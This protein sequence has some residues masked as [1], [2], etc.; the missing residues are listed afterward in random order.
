[1]REA[2]SRLRFRKV[3]SRAQQAGRRKGERAFRDSD[4]LRVLAG[5]AAWGLGLWLVAPSGMIEWRMLLACGV[6][7]IIIGFGGQM[8]LT[9]IQS[10]DKPARP[11]WLLMLS[12]MLLAMIDVRL[13]EWLLSRLL[14]LDVIG[15]PPLVTP[16]A[17]APLLV[18]MLYGGQTALVI[19]L[20]TGV[21]LALAADFSLGVFLLSLCAT[22]V[23]A[24][25]VPRL[26]YRAQLARALGRIALWQTPVVL[27]M[28]IVSPV[29]SDLR[30]V[31]L[32]LS[33]LLV[34]LALSG[35]MVL[36]LL[37]L[38][39]RVTGRTG[40]ISLNAYADLGRPLMQRL[41]LEAPG[42]YHHVMVVANL[43][44]AAADKIGANGLLARVGAYYHDIGKLGRPQFYMENQM[45]GGNPHDDLPPNISRMIIVNH[46]KEGLVLARLHHLPAVVARFIAVHHGT[47][48]IRWFHRKALSHAAGANGGK[49][50]AGVEESHYRY[51]GP[52]PV[53]REETIV[54]L[55]DAIEAGARALPRVTPAHIESLVTSICNDRWSD[56][57]LDQSLLSNAELTAVRQSFIFTLTHLLHARLAYPPHDPNPNSKSA[58]RLPA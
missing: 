51:T 7:L 22:A 57:Q 8:L 48:V 56:G 34:W 32:Q 17:L 14:R 9:V 5:I 33:I 54:S 39:E 58:A 18:A 44:Q 23:A 49:P 31:G 55:A 25:E 16:H 15:G 30:R 6:T 29:T 46:V 12:M 41:I 4:E 11:A 42:T 27:V 26:R 35:L 20:I 24:L 53:S 21:A 40:S 2:L 1:M 38:A 19:G 36:F 52:L 10:R 37:P 28:A 43:A 47:S 45:H 3:R 50:A 13:A